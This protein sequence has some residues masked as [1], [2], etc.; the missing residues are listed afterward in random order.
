MKRRLN[1]AAALVH[2]PDLLI[3][4]EPTVGIDPQS[5]NAIFD[6]LETLAARGK[7][8]VYTTHYMEEAERLADH[9]VI[10]DHGRV[11]A[12][13][14]PTALIRA[15]G[16]T[17]VITLEVSGTVDVA[18]LLRV[19]CQPRRRSAACARMACR[20]R[21]RDTTYLQFSRNAR[22]RFSFADRPPVAR[23]NPRQSHEREHERDTRPRQERPRPLF[24]E[25]PRLAGHAG[26][27]DRHRRILRL[28]VRR[29]GR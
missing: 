7:A 4:D 25:S 3:L 6:N 21:P 15:L 13:D 27:A 20:A 17:G 19:R 26:C 11:V 5:R 9:I 24:F 2:D 22:R 10:I 18:S 23:L 28:A 1:I 8:I 14:T 12:S 16:D 29:L